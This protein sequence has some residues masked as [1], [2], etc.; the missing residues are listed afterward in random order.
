MENIN[1][2][3]QKAAEKKFSDFINCLGL[4]SLPVDSKS[5]LLGEFQN[6]FNIILKILQEDIAEGKISYKNKQ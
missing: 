6:D 3:E 5:L 2:T 4:L 1:N